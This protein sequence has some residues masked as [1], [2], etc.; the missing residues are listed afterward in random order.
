LDKDHS[1]IFHTVRAYDDRET[2]NSYEYLA[3]NQNTIIKVITHTDCWTSDPGKLGFLD[4]HVTGNPYNISRIAFV[5]NCEKE[6]E[7]INEFDSQTSQYNPIK[8]SANLATELGNYQKEKVT[9]L[10]PTIKKHINENIIG[11]LE[12]EFNNIGRVLP[13]MRDVCHKFKSSF[14]RLVRD[15]FE[16]SNT[17]YAKNVTNLN[18]V[19]TTTDFNMMYET[20]VPSID[21]IATELESGSRRKIQGSEGYN[22]LL[23]KYLSNLYMIAEEQFM[24]YIND[25]FTMIF[26]NVR[27]T[28]SNANRSPAAQLVVEKLIVDCEKYIHE[29]NSECREYIHSIIESKKNAPYASNQHNILNNTIY[30]DIVK[31]VINMISSQQNISTYIDEIKLDIDSFIN[32]I[33]RNDG[34]SI[35]SLNARCARHLGK[36]IW[37]NDTKNMISLIGS[38]VEA[39]DIKIEEDIQNKIRMIESNEFAEPDGIDVKRNQLLTI[40]ENCNIIVDSTY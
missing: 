25:R 14:N 8:G 9:E 18:R 11:L 24:E 38:E 13:D 40:E 37:N 21:V 4:K 17:D 2:D 15:S 34:C 10:L 28:L 5:N 7:L 23:K 1:I 33:S 30:K 3:G 29:S 16:N 12:F 20:N 32:L 36:E 31:N 27:L 39:F 22:D 35:Y 19:F 26:D 6:L